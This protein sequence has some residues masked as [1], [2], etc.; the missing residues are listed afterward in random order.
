M[1]EMAPSG[2]RL[3]D[4]LEAPLVDIFTYT[5]SEVDIRLKLTRMRRREDQGET[6][7]KQGR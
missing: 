2:C 3:R 4:C 7:E 1:V 6:M 5:A